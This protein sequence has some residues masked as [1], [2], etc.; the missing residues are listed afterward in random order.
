MGI[1]RCNKPG[2][3]S[4]KMKT[5]Y[6][7]VEVLFQAASTRWTILGWPFKIRCGPLEMHHPSQ[8]KATYHN[9]HLLLNLC[10]HRLIWYCDT[11]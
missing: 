1:K 8:P 2:Q 7:P 4:I 9:V 3:Y 10:E 11:F 6:T 5:S